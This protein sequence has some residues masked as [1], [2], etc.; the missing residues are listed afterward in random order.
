MGRDDGG[1][2]AGVGADQGTVTRAVN[3]LAQG[4]APTSVDPD[5]ARI[6]EELKQ[7]ATAKLAKDPLSRI[8]PTELV[9]EAFIKLFRPGQKQWAS[10]A[11]FYGS[12]GRAMQQLLIDR[13]RRR[14]N[15][16]VQVETFDQFP[17]KAAFDPEQ[18]V[19][20]MEELGRHDERMAQIINLRIFAGLN[21]AQTAEAMQMSM[22]HLN[23]NYTFA[24]AWLY[25][26]LT[27][28]GPANGSPPDPRRSNGDQA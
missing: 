19:A 16:P 10:R 9:H 18:V 1:A 7:L 8:Q 14:K 15:E 28:E 12:A 26:H 20:A 23:R 2:V 21:A 25:R 17:A 3:R 4:E 24:I 11:H 6:Y 27:E 5:L 13:Y 22:R